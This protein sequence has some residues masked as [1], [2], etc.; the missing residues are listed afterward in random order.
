MCLSRA[1]LAPRK[2]LYLIQD[3]DWSISMLDS[4]S[5]IPCAAG[6]GNYGPYLRVRLVNSCLYHCNSELKIS[7]K[8]SSLSRSTKLKSLLV[9]LIPVIFC[10]YNL[11]LLRKLAKGVTLLS[12]IWQVSGS[13]LGRYT[14]C[15]HCS[16]YVFPHSLQANVRTVRTAAFLLH[17][18]QII[19]NYHSFMR[20]IAMQPKL[21]TASLKKLQTI[22]I[23]LL[24]SFFPN[25]SLLV[26]ELQW[27]QKI[28]TEPQ[29]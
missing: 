20:R 11:C 23:A 24:R 4:W 17:R 26:A 8:H 14:S 18:F 28:Q 9:R 12:C 25:I 1:I 22:T 5:S 19:I 29:T 2:V 21:L 15:P 27:T 7:Y 13:N 10:Q 6:R 3:A 16:S